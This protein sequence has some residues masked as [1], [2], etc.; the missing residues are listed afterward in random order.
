MHMAYQSRRKA[1]KYGSRRDDTLEYGL[2]NWEPMTEE[3]N[4]VFLIHTSQRED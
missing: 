3:S 1:K 2:I 4:V